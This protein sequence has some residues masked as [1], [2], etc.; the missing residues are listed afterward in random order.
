MAM[1]T[2]IAW[3]ARVAVIL[4]AFQGVASH[5]HAQTIPVTPATTATP[6]APTTLSITAHPPWTWRARSAGN[7]TANP[8][9]CATAVNSPTAD[10]PV[11]MKLVATNLSAATTTFRV[12]DVVQ[13]EIAL[14]TTR[15][16]D[17]NAVQALRR[18]PGLRPPIDHRTFR[19]NPT[20]RR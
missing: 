7:T 20:Y 13:V 16:L 4:A 5:V 14:T 12:G 9:T 10:C 11:T 18:L 19:P 17:I 3:S 2:C 8:T 6:V 15:A 1:A